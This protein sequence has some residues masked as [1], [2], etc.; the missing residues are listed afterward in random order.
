M[1]LPY[2]W[3]RMFLLDI[4]GTQVKTPTRNGLVCHLTSER[5]PHPLNYRLLHLLLV[6][7]KLDDWTLLQKTPYNQVI[8]WRKK[9]GISLVAY[10]LQLLRN[11]NPMSTYFLFCTFI[12]A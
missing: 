5:P 12:S 10:C 8:M 6:T 4:I 3:E 9:A 7:S 11:K 2:I 1:E